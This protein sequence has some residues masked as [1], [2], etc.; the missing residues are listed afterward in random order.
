MGG[1]GLKNKLLVD[2]PPRYIG[3]TFRAEKEILMYCNKEVSVSVLCISE[4]RRN[5]TR[6]TEAVKEMGFHIEDGGLCVFESV[7]EMKTEYAVYAPSCKY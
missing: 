4:L 3:L 5:V 1:G 6:R 2:T 7:L